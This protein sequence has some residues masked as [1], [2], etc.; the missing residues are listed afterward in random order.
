M[1]NLPKKLAEETRKSGKIIKGASDRHYNTGVFYAKKGEYRRARAEF[2]EALKINPDHA[3]ALYNLGQIYSTHLVDKEK[4]VYYFG[5]YL[6]VC[7]DAGD[8]DLVREYIITW[9]SRDRRG[10]KSRW[11]VLGDVL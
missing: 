6:R 3:F 7:P 9:K 2:K 8:K 4:A 11:N 10:K 5:E 1:A